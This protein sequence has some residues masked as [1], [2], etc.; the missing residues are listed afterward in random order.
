MLLFSCYFPAFSCCFSDPPYFVGPL[1]FYFQSSHLHFLGYAIEVWERS[2]KSS[3][4]KVSSLSSVHAMFSY[5]I[6]CRI[7]YCNVGATIM[8]DRI[9]HLVQN[10][11]VTADFRDHSSLKD[12]IEKFASIKKSSLHH[13]AIFSLATSN[14]HCHSCFCNAALC[15]CSR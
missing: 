13:D 7:Q 15:Q 1:S 9:L 11:N 6:Q 4:Q 8:K 12:L 3:H 2:S 10:T 5:L 14:S